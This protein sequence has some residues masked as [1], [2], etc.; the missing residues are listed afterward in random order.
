MGDDNYGQGVALFSVDV[1]TKINCIISGSF[2]LSS[3]WAA[4]EDC[5][6]GLWPYPNNADRFI[7]I[8]IITGPLQTPLL[9]VDA[10]LEMLAQGL[11]DFDTFD[12]EGL[13]LLSFIGDFGTQNMV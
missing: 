7:N 10:S 6:I 4:L 12:L 13:H 11:L 5:A 8:S 9:H 1:D 2:L 3:G